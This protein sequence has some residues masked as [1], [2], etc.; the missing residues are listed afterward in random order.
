MRARSK[1][2]TKAPGPSAD[3]GASWNNSFYLTGSFAASQYYDDE[4]ILV[5][6][7]EVASDLLLDR[8][9][10]FTSC[11]V[12]VRVYNGPKNPGAMLACTFASSKPELIR[13]TDTGF[14]QVIDKDV[15]VLLCSPTTSC[16]AERFQQLME[17]ALAQ[18]TRSVSQM[19]NHVNM[20]FAV[21]QLIWYF[22]AARERSV[23]SDSS[24]VA[25]RTA[26][27]DSNVRVRN[28]VLMHSTNPSFYVDE[29]CLLCGQGAPLSILHSSLE[30]ISGHLRR[31]QMDQPAA[32]QPLALSIACLF[33]LLSHS[34]ASKPSVREGIASV[35]VQMVSLL[36]RENL[37]LSFRA[38]ASQLIQAYI[39]FVSA[40]YDVQLSEVMH[41]MVA[42]LLGLFPPT[43]ISS[44][45]STMSYE[46]QQQFVSKIISGCR[47]AVESL[48][49]AP[50]TR[51]LTQDAVQRLLDPHSTND[52]TVEELKVVSPKLFP[53]GSAVMW[54][55][56]RSL[57]ECFAGL[58]NSIGESIAEKRST[59][60][61]LSVSAH[62]SMLRSLS[63]LLLSLLRSLW[64]LQPKVSG[65]I[66]SMVVPSV[67]SFFRRIV[68]WCDVLRIAPM[69][70][71][72]LSAAVA[73]ILALSLAKCEVPKLSIVSHEWLAR[74]STATGALCH[75]AA[76][77]ECHNF[78]VAMSSVY[79]TW[80]TKAQEQDILKTAFHSLVSVANDVAVA[81]PSPSQLLVMWE[82]IR[83]VVSVFEA[84]V[85]EPGSGPTRRAVARLLHEVESDQHETSAALEAIPELRGSWS[86]YASWSLAH[87]DWHS[88]SA[89][90]VT[91]SEWASLQPTL[92]YVCSFV[93]GEKAKERY[94]TVGTEL[95]AVAD[96]LMQA[97]CSQSLC[98]IFVES[99]VRFLL[100]RGGGASHSETVGIASSAYASIL[101]QWISVCPAMRL[102]QNV[103][104]SESKSR[105]LSALA[106][107]ISLQDSSSG[108]Q[109]HR[110]L[111]VSDL[112]YLPTDPVSAGLSATS[113]SSFS[114]RRVKTA[115]LDQIAAAYGS[116]S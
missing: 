65:H 50:K 78:L 115:V 37:Y 32:A 61:M 9:V 52:L 100:D 69:W 99:G 2:T 26:A 111:I 25:L 5:E 80:E 51:F 31:L 11:A 79:P 41:I 112:E 106:S 57:F 64:S 88:S 49:P 110:S 36:C 48:F 85:S 3:P 101:F 55:S 46:S 59:A 38:H 97:S 17:N 74:L 96:V 23:A 29:F 109:R 95:L 93:Q 54:A 19:M 82:D 28:A 34:T 30:K 43:L 35:I 15:S 68:C 90:W 47:F 18:K 27:D 40:S 113:S 114:G 116:A 44:R 60:V 83:E 20:T 108:S 105:S 72:V 75:R 104:A 67:N 98:S 66:L 12:L 21:G 56:F 53:D 63:A 86:D 89:E 102:S 70:E 92:W 4:G 77:L 73:Y 81:A 103:V 76:L 45:V 16:S 91:R 14:F 24:E 33:D 107:N 6:V 84:L 62:E 7:V 58:E 42:S 1:S 87:R 22:V 10:E 94:T 8:F 39:P 13:Y 71:S